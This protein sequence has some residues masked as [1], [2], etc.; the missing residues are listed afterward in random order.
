M[1]SNILLNFEGEYFNF[2]DKLLYVYFFEMVTYRCFILTIIGE[3]TTPSASCVVFDWNE[4][5]KGFRVYYD[6]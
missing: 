2:L 4:H 5:V 3:I 6:E 1:F